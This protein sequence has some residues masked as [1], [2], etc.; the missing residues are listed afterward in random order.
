MASIVP[1]K[2]PYIGFDGIHRFGVLM[3]KGVAPIGTSDQE[4]YSLW[5]N[6]LYKDTEDEDEDGRESGSGDDR[7]VSDH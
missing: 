6:E 3:Y 2:T 7:P 4:A 5:W 1:S